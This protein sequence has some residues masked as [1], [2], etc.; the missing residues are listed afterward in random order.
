MADRKKLQEI[1]QERNEA[2]EGFPATSSVG[3]DLNL[4]QLT[5]RAL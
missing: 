5:P 4:G 3:H 1:L 2:E